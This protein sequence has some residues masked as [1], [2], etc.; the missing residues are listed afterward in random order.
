MIFNDE[1]LKRLKES[2][3]GDLPEFST[4]SKA[5]LMVLNKLL[6][7]LEAAEACAQRLS[8]VYPVSENGLVNKWRKAKGEGE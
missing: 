1:D 4:W 5:D 3:S 6:A 7:R 2:L 8:E